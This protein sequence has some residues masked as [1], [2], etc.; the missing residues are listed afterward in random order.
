MGLED[1]Q[2][3]PQV[4]AETVGCGFEAAAPPAGLFVPR[5]GCDRPTVWLRQHWWCAAP[6]G[7]PACC[8][9]LLRHEERAAPQLLSEA[10]LLEEVHEGRAALERAQQLAAEHATWVDRFCFVA[11][12]DDVVGLGL[13]ARVPCAKGQI[14]CEYG[15]PR[16]PT[17]LLTHGAYALQVP[18]TQHFIDGHG[19]NSPMPELTLPRYP[20]TF[21]NH[22]RLPNAEFLRRE[23]VARSPWDVRFRLYI[24]ATEPIPSGAE[25]RIDYENGRT[26][27]YW[28]ELGFTPSESEWRSRRLVTPTPSG[29]LPRMRGVGLVPASTAPTCIPPSSAADLIDEEDMDTEDGGARLRPSGGGVYPTLDL[30]SVLEPP[31]PVPFDVEEDRRL[32]GLVPKLLQAT[33]SNWMLIASHL[34]GRTGSECRERWSELHHDSA[35]GSAPRRDRCCLCHTTEEDEWASLTWIQCDACG[36]W[37]HVGC[38]GI[39]ERHA[40]SRPSWRCH[41]CRDSGGLPT[42]PGA[43][44][45]AGRAGNS[46]AAA[47]AHTGIWLDSHMVKLVTAGTRDVTGVA[48]SGRNGGGGGSGGGGGG[49]SGPKRAEPSSSTSMQVLTTAPSRS[50]TSMPSESSTVFRWLRGVIAEVEKQDREAKSRERETRRAEEKRVRADQNVERQV[51]GRL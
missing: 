15:G 39:A 29:A 21:A 26:S 43:G 12:V 11:R 16:L 25:I 13:F 36:L 34:P 7:S 5:C 8:G 49:S 27:G 17:R 47:A 23:S 40:A 18:N 45:G 32:Y 44:P 38:A 3:S 48:R 2:L 30:A 28:N 19:E 51:H 31:R 24:V 1:G 33:K 46:C 10:A 9:F 41:V 50:R 42:A 37:A 35:Q 4:P 20:A 14:V 6:A 22:S